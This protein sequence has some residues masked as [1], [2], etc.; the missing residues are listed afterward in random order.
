MPLA[1]SM[2]LATR[3]RVSRKGEQHRSPRNW[4]IAI[5]CT[6]QQNRAHPDVWAAFMRD[7][8]QWMQKRR[9]IEN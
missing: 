9:P 4:R 7:V 8:A 2:M 5:K 3:H 6:G 1:F